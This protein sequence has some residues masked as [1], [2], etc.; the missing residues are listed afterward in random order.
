MLD[1]WPFTEKVC[2]SLEMVT[3]IRQLDRT[4]GVQILGQTLFWMFLQ[5][6]LG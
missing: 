3:F 1:I 2:R 5:G 4:E 6:D